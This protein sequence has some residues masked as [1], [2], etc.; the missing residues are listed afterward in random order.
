MT[1]PLQKE[2]PK[3][4]RLAQYVDRLVEC[5]DEDTDLWK[6]PDPDLRALGVSVFL[7]QEH[8]L[9]MLPPEIARDYRVLPAVAAAYGPSVA[10]YLADAP[11]AFLDHYVSLIQEQAKASASARDRQAKKRD[12]RSWVEA[13]IMA[14]LYD[15]YLSGE[16]PNRNYERAARRLGINRGAVRRADIACRRRMGG[17]DPELKQACL[18]ALALVVAKLREYEGQLG[19]ARGVRS[20]RF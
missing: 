9:W 17:T 4:S 15:G 6:S 8:R 10:D 11:A 14:A 19:H 16:S 20:Q 5:A 7:T 2:P 3:G 13:V 12:V 18:A 1:R